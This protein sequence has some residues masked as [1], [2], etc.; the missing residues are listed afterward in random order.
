MTY[1]SDDAGNWAKYEYTSDGMLKTAVLSTGRER[2]Y[3]Y[4]GDQMRMIT[5]ERGHTLVRNFY[6]FGELTEQKFGNGAVYSYTYTRS[7][8]RKYV[9]VAH[10]TMPDGQVKDVSVG[11]SVPWYVRRD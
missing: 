7:D 5:D 1:A 6:V 9:D 2:H 10:V 8:N 4:D 11:G 3:T